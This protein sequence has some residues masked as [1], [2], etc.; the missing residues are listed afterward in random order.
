MLKDTRLT[1]PSF[2]CCGKGHMMDP[3]INRGARLASWCK[4]YTVVQCSHR[5]AMPTSWHNAYI[6]VQGLHRSAM[7]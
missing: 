7:Y 2:V 1:C 4:T 3:T 5:I 6:V